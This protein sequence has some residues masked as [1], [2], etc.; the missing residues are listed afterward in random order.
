MEHLA[1]AVKELV[2]MVADLRGEVSTLEMKL[3]VEREMVVR[4]R[5]ELA[6]ARA[7]KA[8]R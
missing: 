8:K 2:G 6:E 4:L 3:S 7:P 5:T 1:I